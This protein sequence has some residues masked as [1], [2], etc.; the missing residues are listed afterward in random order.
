[1]FSESSKLQN[2]IDIVG[3]LP[4]LGPRSA[5]RIVLNL[6]AKPELM[7]KIENSLQDVRSNIF[8][9]VKCW[10]IELAPTCTVCNDATR[11]SSLLCIVENIGEMWALERS[12]AFNG[13]YHIL[14]G[15]LSAL[16]GVTPEKLN[17]DILRERMDNEGIKEVIVAISA[18]LDGQTTTYHIADILSNFPHIKLTRLAYGI[19]I[20]G[21]IGYMDEATIGVAFKTRQHF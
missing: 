15:V 3:K 9:C 4:G 5:R 8:K 7:K 14:G 6:I 11:D 10:N 18:T 20:G 21:D 17:L 2:L 13:R 16:H 1:M 19:P 12:S